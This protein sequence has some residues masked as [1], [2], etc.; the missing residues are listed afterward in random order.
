MLH[1]KK[2]IFLVLTDLLMYLILEL[3]IK[4]QPNHLKILKNLVIEHNYKNIYLQ[5]QDIVQLEFMKS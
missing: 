2:I 5:K 1:Q 4:N 3:I